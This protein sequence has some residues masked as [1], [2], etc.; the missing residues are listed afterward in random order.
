MVPISGDILVFDK[1]LILSIARVC[2]RLRL[3]IGRRI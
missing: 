3:C 1:F 2:V